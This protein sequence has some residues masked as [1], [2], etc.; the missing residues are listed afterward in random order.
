MSKRLIEINHMQ[1]SFKLMNGQTV[2]PVDDV[3]ITIDEGDVVGLVGESG[4]G[5]SMT[6]LSI[7]RL[8]PP[9]GVVNGGEG[10]FEGK[11]I[12]KLSQ[13]ELTNFRGNKIAMIFQD[14][15]TYLNPV[16]TIE[17]QIGETIVLH[18]SISWEQAKRQVVEILKEVGI[19]S[20]ER[21]AKSYPFE[22]SGGMR[23][24][25]LIAM[26]ISCK[27]KLLI[28]DEPTTALDVTVQAQ[29]L[30]LLKKLVARNKISMLLITH[31]LGIVADTCHKI[32]VMYAGQVV[33][34]GSADDIYYHASH[35]YT[36]ALLQ[37]VLRITERKERINT[38]KGFVPDL[39]NLPE[40]C[41]F[42]SR[43]EFAG[44]GC[45]EMPGLYEVGRDHFSRCIL[46]KNKGENYGK[47]D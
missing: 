43:C 4:C 7:T 10:L 19:A 2:H 46:C 27:P 16:M 6:A 18:M 47:A 39:L 31:D 20:P 11:D 35:P 37:S 34:S 26:A 1:T 22:L 33:E 24:R 42:Q 36:K 32:Y 38:I 21:V 3:S 14:P 25:V 9:P 40:G 23:Q 41:R 45:Q 28:A 17:K 8:V 5:K 29:I 44:S 30:A 12:F 15:M 13:K